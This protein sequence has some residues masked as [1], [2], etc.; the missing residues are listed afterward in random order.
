MVVLER[1]RL[2]AGASGGAAA[3][4]GPAM[5]GF[6]DP[7]A[8]VALARASLTRWRALDEQW[9]GALGIRTLDYLV[10][11]VDVLPESARSAPGVELLD[12][13]GVRAVEPELA[14]FSAGVLFPDQ[15]HVHPLHAAAE[16]ARR[17]GPANV[18]T[19]VEMLDVE[20]SGG[21]VR[22]VHTSAGP[23]TPGAVVFATGLAPA[24][25]GVP[26]RLVKGH[27][28]ATVPAPFRL[29]TVVNAPDALVVQLP[30]GRL[31]TGG[32]LDDGDDD[33]DPD[34]AVTGEIAARLHALLPATTA[35]AVTHAWCCFRPMAADG[36]P[37]ID[38]VTGLDDA[39]V[40][41]G[42]YRT[43]I[44]MA[45][46]TG[47]SLARWIGSGEVPTE[48]STFGTARFAAS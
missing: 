39:W 4:L 24:V 19:G 42:H 18:A 29:R 37:V 34:P 43:G 22:A 3:L 11:L 26:Q 7:P 33:P 12:G 13:D 27:L 47:D 46:A 20:V 31:V 9:E 30:D 1:A 17:L 15:A 32:T 21:R 8:F 28:V 2:G 40:T 6:T 38:R 25:A 45:P 23:F 36:Q 14:P 10:P 35:V 44:L 48:V 16:H 41:C 5:H